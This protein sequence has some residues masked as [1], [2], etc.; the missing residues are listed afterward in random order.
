MGKAVTEDQRDRECWVE[1]KGMDQEQIQ[2]NNE[3]KGVETEFF[4]M[5][6]VCSIV[7]FHAVLQIISLLTDTYAFG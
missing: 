3:D 1:R 5:Y 6:E 7:I 2:K 4:L